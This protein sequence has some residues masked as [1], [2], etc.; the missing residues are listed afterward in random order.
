M[1]PEDV[2]TLADGVRTSLVTLK[3]VAGITGSFVCTQNGRLLARELPSLF[4]DVVL[5][6]AGSRLLRVGETFAAGGDELEVA[7]VRYGEHRI[8]LKTIAG[9]MLCIVIAGDINMPALRMAANLVGRRIAPAVARAQAEL[10][11][12]PI[13][14]PRPAVAAAASA[15]ATPATPAAPKSQEAP[16]GMRRFRGRAVE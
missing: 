12:I 13:E 4:E 16:P 14:P 8:Y 5:S 9:G 1:T 2:K 10:P 6:E 3:D 7:V 11:L 15:T